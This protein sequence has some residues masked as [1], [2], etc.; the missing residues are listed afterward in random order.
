MATSNLLK[1]GTTLIQLFVFNAR[2]SAC[3]LCSVMLSF[4]SNLNKEYTAFVR[5][6]AVS[7]DFSWRQLSYI[8]LTLATYQ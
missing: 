1:V 3:H 4:S 6:C 2:R 5:D 7:V 8:W